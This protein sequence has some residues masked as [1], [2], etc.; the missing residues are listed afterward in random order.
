LSPTAA[1]P[2]DVVR[3]VRGGKTI[4]RALANQ[5][6]AP[7]ST[8]LKGTVLDLASGEGSAALRRGA[9]ASRW[10]H[11]DVGHRPDVRADLTTAS[12]P[13][14]D[15]AAD[16]AVLM[17][18]LYIARDPGA[19]LAEIHRVLRP[20]GTLILATPLVFPVT[21]EPHDLWRFTD[22][23]LR[24]L[25]A[26][27]GFDDAEVTPL[28][29]R[30]SSAAFLLGP[31]QRPSRW[32]APSVTRLALSLDRLAERRWGDRLAPNPVGYAVRAVA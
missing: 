22:E 30:W 8:E 21:P 14:R 16:A 2:G 28:G 27:A 1:N 23:G 32:V 15:G 17:W 3:A 29:G 26:G 6:V 25:L 11:V 20:G 31:Y 19:V 10:I 24:M 7:W 9:P 12:L 18:F 5:A 13:F 4:L